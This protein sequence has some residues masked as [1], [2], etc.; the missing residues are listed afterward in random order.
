MNAWMDHVLTG[1]AYTAVGVLGLGL[2]LG[3]AL[4]GLHV[5]AWLGA[6]P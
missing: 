4:T 2:G 6:L 1:F 3:Q 5:Q